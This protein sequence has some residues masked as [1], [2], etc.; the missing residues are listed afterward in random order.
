VGSTCKA[1]NCSVDKTKTDGDGVTIIDG[2][3]GDTYTAA[4]SVDGKIPEAI[5]FTNN[6]VDAN[7]SVTLTQDDI[8]NIAEGVA[9]GIGT[10]S[11]FNVDSDHTWTFNNS[12]QPTAPKIINEVVGFDGLL[13]MDFTKAIP[14]QVSIASV[15]SATF[16]NIS[17]TE[18]TVSASA[19]SANKKQAHITVDASA[20]T[21]NTYT[22][23]V[24]ITTT[25][26]Q[27]FTRSGRVKIN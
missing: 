21:T 5:P 20:A 25:D 9:A 1:I 3:I 10:V 7:A 18:P 4:N 16:A 19:V 17:G 26:S 11:A 27:T 23:T 8:D 22:L 6:K 2:Q 14:Q 15:D 13:A 24:T 12:V